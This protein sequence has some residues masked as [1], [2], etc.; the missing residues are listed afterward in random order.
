MARQ[1]TPKPKVLYYVYG[2][3]NSALLNKTLIIKTQVISQANY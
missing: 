3:E 1:C 2:S